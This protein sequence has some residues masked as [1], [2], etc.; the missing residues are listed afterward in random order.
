MT[1]KELFDLLDKSKRRAHL[2][3]NE[4]NGIVAG[5]DLEGRLFA[6]VNGKVLNRVVPSALIHRSNKTF[7]H[8]PGGDA[9]WP[10]PEGSRFGYEYSTGNWRVPPS[11]SAAVWEVISEQTDRA[12]IRAELDL[13]NNIQL[14]IP[15]EFERHIEIQ[16]QEN[17]LKEEVTE[18]IR[19][20]GNKTLSKDEFLIAPWSLCQFDSGK[21]G[22][23]ILPASSREE[24]WDMYPPGNTRGILKDDIYIINTDTPHRFQLGI[25]ENTPWVEY[26]LE[27]GFRI[28]RYACDL[29]DGQD[30]IDIADISPDSPPSSKGVRY[31]VYCDPSGFM[32]V[33]ACGGCTEIL[34]PGTELS[35]KIITE[36][37]DIS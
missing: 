34:K 8:N 6:I 1:G 29:P 18:L 15:C 22:K 37:Y 35:V 10:A 7:F 27:E 4:Q 2:I 11:V 19:Y 25:G 3:G 30:Y 24:I 14:G 28:K 33:E 23:I 5:L 26:I 12:V 13:I 36:Y 9:L 20:I 17:F 16:I 21:K 32:E 31:S